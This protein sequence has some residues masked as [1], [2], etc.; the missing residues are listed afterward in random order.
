LIKIDTKVQLSSITTT[1]TAAASTATATTAAAAVTVTVT[2][3]VS[4]G[5]QT[6]TV[7]GTQTVTAD[8][9]QTTT[10]DGTQT[11]T[12]DGT[13]IITDDGTQT[14]TVDDSPGCNIWFAGMIHKTGCRID[15]AGQL[16]LCHSGGTTVMFSRGLHM[17][18]G[19]G[20]AN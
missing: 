15:G 8:W 6:I 10:D 18:Y 3:Y 16:A 5:T 9:T 20:I 17:C 12:A 19:V 14:I 2:L 1:A 4:N 13:Q 11:T 7:D